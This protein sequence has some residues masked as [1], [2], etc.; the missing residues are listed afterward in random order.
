MS[1]ELD[2]GKTPA[3]GVLAPGLT[4]ADGTEGHLTIAACGAVGVLIS[5]ESEPW[6]A[7]R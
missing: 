7:R 2:S 1:A 3:F 6:A 5:L 4:D